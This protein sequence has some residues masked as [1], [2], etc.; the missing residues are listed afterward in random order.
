MLLSR[1]VRKPLAATLISAAVIVGLAP[2]M[3]AAEPTSPPGRG[4]ATRPVPR[5]TTPGSAAARAARQPEKIIEFKPATPAEHAAAIARA[6]V[7]AKVLAEQYDMKVREIETDHFL[8]FTDWDE[9]EFDFLKRNVELAY[10]V[11]ARQFRL[12]PKDTIFVGKLPIYMF[13]SKGAFMKFGT[14]VDNIPMSRF[15]GGYYSGEE[16]GNGHMAMPKPDIK[17]GNV[18]EAERMWGYILVHE[19]THAFVARYR[20][21]RRVPTWINEGLAEVIA[22]EAFPDKNR[23]RDAR[24]AARYEDSLA[25]IFDDDLPK[26]A[27]QYPIM[28]TLVE[29]LLD[30]NPRAFLNM[31]NAIKDGTEP[32]EALAKFYRTDYVELEV[33]WRK[34]VK[35][36]NTARRA[37]RPE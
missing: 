23:G 21:N 1:I 36:I 31:F 9:R 20:T 32:K 5:R 26:S 22:S 16:D 19:F 4:P 28:Q 18:A 8:I 27:Y 29:L 2:R 13:A 14:D 15:I 37:E 7:A 33:T 12:N 35:R 30:E 10:A 3:R 25:S 17:N 34:A 24:W 6:R 11:V